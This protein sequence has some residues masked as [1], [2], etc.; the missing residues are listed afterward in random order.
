L[1]QPHLNT[2]ALAGGARENQAWV[3]KA[4]TMLKMQTKNGSDHA[5]SGPLFISASSFDLLAAHLLTLLLIG[6]R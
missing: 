3:W 5:T 6:N 4:V 2:P 1:Q